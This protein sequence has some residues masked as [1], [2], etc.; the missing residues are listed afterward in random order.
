MVAVWVK[1]AGDPLPCSQSTKRQKTPHLY[2]SVRN[3]REPSAHKKHWIPERKR[4]N[5]IKAI[6]KSNWR[7]PQLETSEGATAGFGAPSLRQLIQDNRGGPRGVPC[8]LLTR[9]R[10]LATAD[11][12]QV[13]G[14]EWWMLHPHR[15]RER[16]SPPPGE[17]LPAGHSPPSYPQQPTAGYSELKAGQQDSQTQR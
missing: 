14:I 6:E 9:A 3:K 7:K 12:P 16:G 2:Y 11:L 17:K 13:L 4:T 8:C 5:S 15:E 1:L 10:Q